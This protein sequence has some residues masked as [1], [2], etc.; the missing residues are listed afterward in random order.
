MITGFFEQNRGSATVGYVITKNGGVFS[1]TFDGFDGGLPVKVGNLVKNDPDEF[2]LNYDHEN[3]T[4]VFR[5]DKNDNLTLINAWLPDKGTREDNY[6][7]PDIF[8]KV[9]RMGHTILKNYDGFDA[10]LGAYTRDFS[11]RERKQLEEGRDS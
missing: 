4:E 10:R 1:Y 7:F 5:F 6:T 8:E 3:F 2:H 9:R 11:S